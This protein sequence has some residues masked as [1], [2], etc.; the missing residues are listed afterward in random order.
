[1]LY[2]SAMLASTYLLDKY[3]T[4]A[5]LIHSYKCILSFLYSVRLSDSPCILISPFSYIFFFLMPRRPPRSTR[6]ATLFPSTTLFRSMHGIDA[7]LGDDRQEHRRQDQ[8]QRSPLHE[9]ARDQEQGRDQHQHAGR[10]LREGEEGLSHLLRHALEGQHPAEG[11]GGGRSE[12]HTSELQSLMRISYAV[13]CLKK[14][15]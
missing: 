10:A 11:G 5:V 6:T 13:F 9:H 7:E 4:V 12:E 14:K 2:V 1:M 8:D 15:K 3:H